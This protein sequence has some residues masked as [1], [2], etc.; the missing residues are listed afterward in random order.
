MVYLIICMTFTI[1]LIAPVSAEK[2]MACCQQTNSGENCRYTFADECNSNYQIGNFQFCEDSNFCK[3][4]CCISPEGS[5]SK[6][7]SK[8]TCENEGEGWVWADNANCELEQCQKGCCVL[9]ESECKFT[10]EKKCAKIISQFEGLS[11][12]FRASNSE[13]ECTAICQQSDKGCCVKDDGSC[14]WESRGS[15]AL[16]DGF[17]SSG[18]YKDAY[19]SHN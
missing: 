5:C 8:F 10:T 2:N 12:D 16:N 18:F 11:L 6:Q 3:P 1:S 19:C 9:A 13:T 14:T 17:G 4:G 7:V 15:C